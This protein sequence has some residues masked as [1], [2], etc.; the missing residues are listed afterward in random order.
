[1]LT[2]QPTPRLL[3]FSD[4]TL[5]FTT[6][7]TPSVQA[8]HIPS[9]TLLPSGPALPSQPALLALSSSAHILLSASATPPTI[10]LQ[11]RTT[12]APPTFLTP[13][14]S[15]APAVAAAFHPSRPDIFALAFADGSV[16][17]Y[18]AAR[19]SRGARGATSRTGELG[20][21]TK[22][23]AAAHAATGLP[24]VSLSWLPG[25]KARAVSVGLDG[26]AHVLDF[27]TK[28][29]VRSW[30]VRGPAT[31]VAAARGCVAVGR[32][33]G[34][35]GIWDFAGRGVGDVW[36]DE[37]AGQVLGVEWIQ[38]PAPRQVVR[39]ERGVDVDIWEEGGS[40][41]SRV[42][43]AAEEEGQPVG[44]A[45]DGDAAADDDEADA[46]VRRRHGHKHEHLHLAP[47]PT[48]YMDLFSP[49]K[50]AHHHHHHNQPPSPRKP[51]YRPRLEPDTFKRLAHTGLKVAEAVGEA[52]RSPLGKAALHA[53][54]GVPGVGVGVA[55]G[56]VLV[57]GVK[58]GV[59]AI[60][61][62]TEEVKD[63][64]DEGK[65]QG[66]KVAQAFEPPANARLLAD[67]KRLGAQSGLEPYAR[68]GASTSS[69]LSPGVAAPKVTASTPKKPT[70]ARTPHRGTH[71]RE[72][73][74]KRES[75]G[76]STRAVLGVRHHKHT[77][78][79]TPARHASA[80]AGTPAK[81][82]IWLAS[83]SPVKDGHLHRHRL[84]PG[85]RATEPS[86]RAP[87]VAT[88][89]ASP[90]TEGQGRRRLRPGE[91]ESF[92]GPVSVGEYL[93]RRGSLAVKPGGKAV[94]GECPC[95]PAL[96]AEVERLK[97]EVARLKVQVGREPMCSP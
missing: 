1:M 71:D 30:H 22:L 93:P 38:G 75:L 68:R 74:E 62:V 90:S 34:R 82:D 42:S 88:M 25:F 87:R 24:S 6:T 21:F 44:D 4:Q 16:C 70:K 79:A 96:R 65:R 86:P 84:K 19:V 10:S 8:Y 28:S 43:E 33:D 92:V 77:N 54:E 95:C 45:A 32:A 73:D 83:P 91:A 60:E 11:N 69:S 35:V 50:P 51:L 63:T 72:R 46:T 94:R 56:E 5:Y 81:E 59:E 37:G 17:A 15:S 13:A 76:S 18:D 20:S 49:P 97:Q 64:V 52:V 27:E 40:V 41:R 2:A 3:T 57:E 29:V 89:P 85:A 48:G 80:A 14:T 39:G 9:Q 23:H 67:M 26:R 58:V 78:A 12:N 53:A 47:D 66:V 36:A 31:C 61:K 55:L 7:I